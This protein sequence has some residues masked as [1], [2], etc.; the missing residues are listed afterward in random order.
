MGP[1]I[2]EQLE[3]SPEGGRLMVRSLY[4]R[5]KDAGPE[6]N[7]VLNEKTLHFFDDVNKSHSQH[8]I[9]IS[10]TANGTPSGRENL[11]QC[12]DGV[13]IGSYVWASETRRVDQVLATDADIAEFID[14]LSAHYE[15][16]AKRERR[17]RGKEVYFPGFLYYVEHFA[18]LLPEEKERINTAY[19]KATSERKGHTLADVIGIF[20]NRR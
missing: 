12:T 1:D 18:D 11:E 3:F 2:Q 13:T 19:T 15:D 6:K 7:W 20:R 14:A 9:A 10:Y 17:K 5:E 8:M 4:K 16:L